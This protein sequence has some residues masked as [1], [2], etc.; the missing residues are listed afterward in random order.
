M[1]KSPA[2]NTSITMIMHL[3]LTGGS[4]RHHVEGHGSMSDTEVL[5]EVAHEAQPG[6][7][8]I[9]DCVINRLVLKNNRFDPL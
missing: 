7:P 8:E 9:I 2:Q 6:G 5:L 3:L 1:N 4:L